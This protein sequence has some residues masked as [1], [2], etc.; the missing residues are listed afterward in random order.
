MSTK[1]GI[2]KSMHDVH[3]TKLIDNE[4]FHR[5]DFK[6]CIEY[7]KYYNLTVA[8]KVKIINEIYSNGY[9]SLS[10]IIVVGPKF[11]NDL[12]EILGFLKLF[13]HP[14]LLPSISYSQLEK[15]SELELVSTM[16]SNKQQAQVIYNFLV[17]AG[18]SDISVLITSGTFELDLLNQL[19]HCIR[20]D[21]DNKIS[22][23]YTHVIDTKRNTLLN[24]ESFS[25]IFLLIIIANITP[26]QFK[27][28]FELID[29]DKNTTLIFSDI[30]DENWNIFKER[31]VYYT[32]AS[33]TIKDM[34]R[35][36]HE[37]MV[38]EFLALK[39]NYIKN[40]LKLPFHQYLKSNLIPFIKLRHGNSSYIGRKFNIY[41]NINTIVDD[42]FEY[43][44]YSKNITQL[45][46]LYQS[47][48][49]PICLDGLERNALDNTCWTC[50]ACER[51][52]DCIHCGNKEMLI[53]TNTSKHYDC[54]KIDFCNVVL[55]LL[56]ILSM[57]YIFLKRNDMFIQSSHSE[58]DFFIQIGCI[59]RILSLWD[60][61][62]SIEGICIVSTCLNFYGFIIITVS[63]IAKMINCWR[64]SICY[65]SPSQI[66]VQIIILSSIVM[67]F[68][69]IM[70]Y[71]VRNDIN[72]HLVKDFDDGADCVYSECFS[73]NS[74]VMFLMVLYMYRLNL[75]F[76]MAMILPKAFLMR[77]Y[78]ANW[79]E[80]LLLY[81]SVVFIL[82]FEIIHKIIIIYSLPLQ[83]SS[84]L[85]KDIE[86]IILNII[87]LFPFGLI[88]IY[89]QET[90]N[91]QDIVLNNSY[92]LKM[93]KIKPRTFLYMYINYKI[94]NATLHIKHRLN[95]IALFV[96][97]LSV[98]GSFIVASFQIT[99]V[100]NVHSL[101]AF[102]VF[103]AGPIYMVIITYLYHLTNKFGQAY[104]ALH[105]KQVMYFRIVLMVITIIV[106][107]SGLITTIL[108]R[109][110]K[111][112][113][114]QA[115][116]EYNIIDNDSKLHIASV[117]F[118]WISF[119]IY[120]TFISTTIEL[121]QNVK[122]I[123]IVLEMKHNLPLLSQVTTL[124][125]E[126]NTN[127]T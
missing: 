126:S 46:N 49:Q 30:Y 42:T 91:I 108:S 112:N 41:R 11:T 105:T 107:L 48:C 43:F 58:I 82:T 99:N 87:L 53:L 77:K 81:R 83:F 109:Y 17:D 51:Y 95:L 76:I 2:E 118:E 89:V 39:K 101:G 68:A 13:K 34:D 84:H 19:N 5:G 14:V 69:S 79:H 115:N 16:S 65:R 50:V 40:K 36:T 124:E 70:I 72:H 22:V 64:S 18:A 117:S 27:S 114:N 127:E 111:A 66:I 98:I 12:I 56:H 54:K 61:F 92:I 3:C 88:K 47:N 93:N 103:I 9:D 28:E 25:K 55:M 125:V 7:P 94:V 80:G 31:T 24:I 4:C 110:E 97:Y 20:E 60:R 102:L 62:I 73:E 35:T 86:I 33:N 106:I 119:L 38:D 96:G 104:S 120:I 78:P 113:T 71:V 74:S 26:Q 90:I 52:Q 1:S 67:I 23:G 121:F 32:G 21:K 63:L 29:I 37:L 45:P 123:K 85:H 8:K 59:L 44:E 122:T 6:Y 116:N 10:C 100:R 57:I 75:I 15:I